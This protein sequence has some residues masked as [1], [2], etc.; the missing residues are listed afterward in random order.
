MLDRVNTEVLKFKKS[1][2]RKFAEAASQI[3]G[4]VSLTIGEPEFNTSDLI[5]DAAKQALDENHTHYPSGQGLLSLRQ[6]VA[7]FENKQCNL[8]SSRPTEPPVAVALPWPTERS[9]PPFSCQSAPMARS[10]P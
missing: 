1:G 3:P 5:K 4:V 8:N 6:A 2:I 7:A 9:K 10:R